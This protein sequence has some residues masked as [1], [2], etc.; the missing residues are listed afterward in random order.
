MPPTELMPPQLAIVTPPSI[1]DS[2]RW[3]WVAEARA[4]AHEH[5]LRYSTFAPGA[6]PDV[7]P[8]L[9]EPTPI[10]GR[11]I[12]LLAAWLV[13]MLAFWRWHRDRVRVTA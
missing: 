2:P 7:W 4:A 3:A 6:E 8:A 11:A 9:P 13:V 5:D 10:A 1:L 12:A